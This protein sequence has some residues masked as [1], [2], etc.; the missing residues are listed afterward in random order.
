MPLSTYFNAF[1]SLGIIIAAILLLGKVLPMIAPKLY[2]V[3]VK[4]K[5]EDKRN[6]H[7]TESIQL[8]PKRRLVVVEHDKDRHLILLGVNSETVVSTSKTSTPKPKKKGAKK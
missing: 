2:G 5:K 6:L 4:K 8:D 1:I 7:L 3:P